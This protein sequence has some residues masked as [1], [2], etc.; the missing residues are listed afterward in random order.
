M[1]KEI[2]GKISADSTICQ[3][4]IGRLYLILGRGI[5]CA[6]CTVEPPGDTPLDD[7]DLE[8]LMGLQQEA[9]IIAKEI[10]L[11]L[12]GKKVKVVEACD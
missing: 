6:I 7:Q 2:E 8:D 4:Q 12:T 9:E 11:A 3:M 10:F 1:I 5:E